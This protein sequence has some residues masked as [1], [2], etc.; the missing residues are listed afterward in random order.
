MDKL[1]TPKILCGDFNLRP[2]TESMKIIEDR[3]HNLIYLYQVNSTRTSLY[4]KEE[5]FADYILTSPEV[6]THRFAVLDHEV[7]DHK[8]LF[9]DFGH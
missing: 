5:K 4:K 8:P 2:D 9:L 3:M 7:S 6:K 1:S